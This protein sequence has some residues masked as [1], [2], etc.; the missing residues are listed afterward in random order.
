MCGSDSWQN[1]TAEVTNSIHYAK[2][3]KCMRLNPSGPSMAMGLTQP[4][5]EMNNVGISWEAVCV[6]V[7]VCVKDGRCVG[8]TTFP[9]SFADCL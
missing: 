7:C 1:E 9:P 2:Q 8:L 6:C 5:T 4:L 3:L